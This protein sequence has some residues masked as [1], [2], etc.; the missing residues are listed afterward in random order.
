[1]IRLFLLIREF[2][3]DSL[4]ER[5]ESRGRENSSG[6]VLSAVTARCTLAWSRPSFAES[7]AWP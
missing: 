6:G 3:S 1:M 5:S 4:R 2:P 7:L